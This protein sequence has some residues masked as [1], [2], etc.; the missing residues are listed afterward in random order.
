[1][2]DKIFGSDKY[3]V[4]MLQKVKFYYGSGMKK[5]WVSVN[6]NF[7]DNV[8]SK[9]GQSVRASLLTGKIIVTEVDNTILN[10]LKTKLEQTKNLESLEFW[11]QKECQATKDDYQK[12][13]C[14]IGAH[15]SA[16]YGEL[17][18]LCHMST[19]NRIEAETDYQ[20]VASNNGFN[21]MVLH[22]LARNFSSGQ[23]Q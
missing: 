14:A 23:L 20:D 12:F 18:T 16:F 6:E 8:G 17:F 21:A 15:L 2:S 1:M 10:K 19:N 13:S 22:I 5:N 7:L 11:E 4:K 9:Y 3:L